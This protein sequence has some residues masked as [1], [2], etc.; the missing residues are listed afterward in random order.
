MKRFQWATDIG[1][2]VALAGVGS[3]GTVFHK[4]CTQR[5]AKSFLDFDSLR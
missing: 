5:R 1:A 3:Y 2:L 4:N